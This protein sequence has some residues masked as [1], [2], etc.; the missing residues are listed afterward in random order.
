MAGR[1]TADDVA[2]RAGVSRAT[3]S[4]VLNNHPHP[5]IPEATMEKSAKRLPS[6]STRRW[7]RHAS[8]AGGAAT[9]SSC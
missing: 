1:V 3:V 6:S 7:R 2:R 4:Y 9:W 8:S 5:S